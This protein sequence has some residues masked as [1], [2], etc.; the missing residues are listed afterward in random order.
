MSVVDKN[1]YPTYASE[2]Q[3]F[4]G[5]QIYMGIVILL[6]E[7]MYFEEDFVCCSSIKNSMSLFR[8]R[9]LCQYFHINNNDLMVPKDSPDFDA[10]Y[11]VMFIISLF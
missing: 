2:V 10:F 8:F 4:L 1:W 7:K 6:E 3:A 5:I 9:K 11:E